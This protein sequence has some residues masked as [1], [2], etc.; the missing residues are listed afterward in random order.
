MDFEDINQVHWTIRTTSA[1]VGTDP[2]SVTFVAGIRP[3]SQRD[4]S[5]NEFPIDDEET[6]TSGVRLTWPAG[7]NPILKGP[8]DGIAAIK[9]F[10]ETQKKAGL[11]NVALKVSPSG[12]AVASAMPFLLLAAIVYVVTEGGKR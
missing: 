7:G 6:F 2:A 3:D 11:R 9:A 5:A 10:A 1:R 4:Y 12:G 8:G